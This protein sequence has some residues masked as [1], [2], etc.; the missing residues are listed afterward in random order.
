MTDF[1][2]ACCRQ[3]EDGNCNRGGRE[4]SF[5][6]P[7]LPIVSHPHA[8]HTLVVPRPFS[9]FVSLVPTLLFNSHRPRRPCASTPSVCNFLHVRLASSGLREELRQAQKLERLVNPKEALIDE[10]AGWVPGQKK[11][12]S[13]SFGG[14]DRERSRSPVRSSGGGGTRAWDEPRRY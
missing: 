1:R 13:S 11:K 2:E 6:P 3:N 12:E 9:P 14:G 8:D 10:S 4:S 7:H 5:P